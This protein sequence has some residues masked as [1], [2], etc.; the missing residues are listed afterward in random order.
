ME[1]TIEQL[2]QEAEVARLALEEAEK[3][4]RQAERE[5]KE[6]L[7]KAEEEQKELKRLEVRKDIC[8]DLKAELEAVGVADIEVTDDFK[9]IWADGIRINIYGWSYVEKIIVNNRFDFKSTNYRP[10]NSGGF[11]YKGIA[12]K[13]KEKADTAKIESEKR[14]E[15]AMKITSSK[16]LAKELCAELGVADD[17][18]IGVIEQYRHVGWSGNRREWYEI[19]PPEGKVFVQLGTYS[20]TPD[21]ARRVVAIFKELNLKK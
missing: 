9:N 13:V 10:L 8:R 7:R 2:K 14:T 12:K 19:T 20:L 6:A 21:E 11:N 1:K 4:A 16:E 5:A 3:A 18:I 15:K 17:L